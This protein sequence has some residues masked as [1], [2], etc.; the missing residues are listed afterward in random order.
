MALKQKNDS[1]KVFDISS[2]E[3]IKKAERY[4]QRLYKLYNFVKIEPV[5][6]EKVALSGFW[7]WR[8]GNSLGNA[9]GARCGRRRG[10]RMTSQS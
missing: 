8:R 5:G 2:E 1:R 6:F 4:Q 9:S 7:I 10:S 3:G